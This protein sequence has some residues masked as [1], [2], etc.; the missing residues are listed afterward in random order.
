MLE[1]NVIRFTSSSNGG[2]Y[3]LL[4]VDRS[5]WVSPREFPVQY[6]S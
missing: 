5:E 1:V 6:S 2:Q 4:H 3:S